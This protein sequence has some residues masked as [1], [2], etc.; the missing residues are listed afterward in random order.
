MSPGRR[1]LQ[2]RLRQA[3]ASLP[4]DAKRRPTGQCGIESWYPYYAGF[5][6]DFA[7]GVLEELAPNGLLRPLTAHVSTTW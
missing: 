6:E 1:N 3:A 4:L 2:V 5:T 7:R